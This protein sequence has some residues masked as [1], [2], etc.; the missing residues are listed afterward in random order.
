LGAI[1]GPLNILYLTPILNRNISNEE[2]FSKAHEFQGSMI[3]IIF[4]L[5]LPF[6][7]FPNLALTILY[8][9]EFRPA[10][11]YLYLFIFWQSMSVIVNVYRQLLV[12]L[13]DVRFF[14]ISTLVSYIVAIVLT[15]YLIER[16]GLSGAAFSLSLSVFLNGL[17]IPFRLSTRFQSSIPLGVWLRISLCLG[18]IIL[19]GLIFSYF[20][21][22]SVMGFLARMLYIAVLAPL[23]WKLLPGEQKKMVIDTITRIRT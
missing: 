18:G 22:F 10:S 12:G 7:L 19:T 13:D 17:V 1:S 16:F 5:S 23:L 9:S 8:S 21:E 15:P 6:L 3:L 11:D 14:S 20:E 4:M 2:K